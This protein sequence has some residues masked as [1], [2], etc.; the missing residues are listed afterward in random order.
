MMSNCKNIV[1]LP[2]DG[3]SHV[4]HRCIH[5]LCGCVSLL[6]VSIKDEGCFMQ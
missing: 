2:E 4:T 6:E 1:I 3:I 5:T